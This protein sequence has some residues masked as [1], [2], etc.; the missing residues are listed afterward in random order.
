MQK[1]QQ[2]VWQLK[3]QYLDGESKDATL[4]TFGFNPELG[5]WSPYHM[6]YYSVIESITK[7]AA[8]GGDY[9]NAR[10][11]FQEY[12]EKLG[13]EAS[14]WGKPFAALLGAYEAQMAFEIPA[15]GGK[16][17][18][19]GSFGDLDVPPTLVSFAVGVEKAKNIISP[20]FKEVGSS[21]V[22]LQTEKLEDETINIDKLKKEFR[23][24]I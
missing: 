7:L 6:A 20:E 18:M 13:T 22:L 3:F 9:R 2:K 5:T 12:F 21:L 4:M 11:T 1:L 17:S 14:R 16:D 8:M 23:S 10:L 24:S 19:S 15:I